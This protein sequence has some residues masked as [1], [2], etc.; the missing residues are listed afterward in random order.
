MRDLARE[1]RGELG[2]QA[3]S[4]EFELTIRRTR[5]YLATSAARLSIESARVAGPTLVVDMAVS[6]L[7]GH[8]LPTAYPSRR[9]WLNVK[10]TGDDGRVVF[11]SGALRADGSIAGNDNDVEGSRYEPHYEVVEQADQVQIYESV[12]VDARD[13][14]TT[15]LLH[16]VRY[17]KDNRLVPLGFDKRTVDDDVGVFGAAAG[18]DDFTAGSDRVRYRVPLDGGSG[19]L[20]IE[21]RLLYQTIGFRW[22]ENLAVYDAEETNRFVSYYR[23]NAASSAVE[24]ATTAVTI[25]Y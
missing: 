13:A 14:V 20:R 23:D 15:G 11:E 17:V 19:R 5:E 3:L 25:D 24:L 18:D 6:N 21:V 10:V 7:A 8:K 4:Q 16:G 22:A 2:V 12:M 1:Y 9:A